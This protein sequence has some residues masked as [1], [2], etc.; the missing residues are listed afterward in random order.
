MNDPIAATLGALGQYADGSKQLSVCLSYAQSLDGS[1]TAQAGKPTAISSPESL[2]MTHQLRALHDCLLIGINTALSD[3]PRLNV[4]LA[5]GQDPVPVILDT[6]LKLKPNSRL[7][8]AH[9]NVQIFCAPPFDKQRAAALI[10][11]GASI[12]PVTKTG[13][14]LLDIPSVLDKLSSLGYRTLMVEGGA[15]VITEF[16]SVQAVDW[17]VLTIGPVLL[18]GLRVPI[19]RPYSQAWSPVNMDVKGTRFYGPDLVIWGKPVWELQ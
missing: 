3:D 9:Q 17:I 1:I 6:E 15:T 4:R 5:E 18:G 19:S 10:G 13:Q 12:H 16:L 7:M 14:G 11:A 2:S 8:S